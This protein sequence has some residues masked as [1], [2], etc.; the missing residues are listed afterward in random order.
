[1]VF[2]AT[3]IILS[4]LTTSVLHAPRRVDL[5]LLHEE[6][7]LCLWAGVVEDATEHVRQLRDG[8]K[9]EGMTLAASTDLS[10][11]PLAGRPKSTGT[12]GRR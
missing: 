6:F 7:I 2:A 4:L 11:Q 8:K 3:L 5:L 10:R 12:C 1:M 9:K